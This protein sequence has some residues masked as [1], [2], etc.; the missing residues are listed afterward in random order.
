MEKDFLKVAY[1]HG[2]NG[3]HPLQGKLARSIGGEYIVVD[4]KIR[5]HDQPSSRIR[6]Y[7]SWVVCALSFPNKKEYDIFLAAG[8]HFTMV[9]MR[10]LFQLNKKQKIVI[11]LGD[12]T[13]YF[14]QAKRYPPLTHKM[15]VWALKKYDV[16]V[17]EGIMG[18]EI[19]RALLGPDKPIYTVFAGIPKEHYAVNKTVVP[20]LNTKNI[21]FM[22]NG[23]SGFRI[24]YK[25]IDLL[26]DSFAIAF[27]KDTQLRLTVIGEWYKEV[28]DGLLAKYDQKTREA[29]K[30]IGATDR[31]Q[32]HLKNAGLYLHCARGEAFGITI[33]IAMLAG[34]VPI[35]T[36]WTGAKEAVG[37]VNR[38]LITPLDPNKIAERIEWYFNLPVEERNGLSAKCREVVENYTEE[39]AIERYRAVFTQILVDQ[40][41]N[42]K[43]NLNYL[44]D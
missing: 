21:I 13:L 14:L 25:G 32:D 34:V 27:S 28:I 41:I 7:L 23:P 19:A 18:A 40:G 39:K 2:R 38:N 29:I 12:E 8:P 24:W 22:G 5:W 33:L 30:F 11:H 26:L 42:K 9:L 44:R 1:V 15:L 3:P 36:E 43:I 10:V 35:V 4:F 17:C 16:V 20:D 37:Q 6:R 31:L